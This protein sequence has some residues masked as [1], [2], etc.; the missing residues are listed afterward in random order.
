VHIF[1]ELN[2]LQVATEQACKIAQLEE[3]ES[4][5]RTVSAL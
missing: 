5:A 2:L 4:K 3:E 1:D